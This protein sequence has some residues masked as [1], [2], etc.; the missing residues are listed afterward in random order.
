[1]ANTVTKITKQYPKSSRKHLK[2]PKNPNFSKA[3]QNLEKISKI[4]KKQT[5][6]KK[7]N[8]FKK[9]TFSK[10]NYLFLKNELFQKIKI[11]VLIQRNAV[12]HR[13]LF[14]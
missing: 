6:S 14:L 2:I 8:F 10:K 5:F 12:R 7:I 3:E 1:V 4:F 13:N 9:R 11:I